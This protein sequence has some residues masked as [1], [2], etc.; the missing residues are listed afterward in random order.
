MGPIS[1]LDETTLGVWE[2]STDI[3]F[4]WQVSPGSTAQEDGLVFVREASSNSSDAACIDVKKIF[5]SSASRLSKPTHTQCVS[6]AFN[7]ALVWQSSIYL[8]F[9]GAVRTGVALT[10][11]VNTLAISAISLNSYS[12]Q[13]QPKA[14]RSALQP[15]S[16]GSVQPH[17]AIIVLVRRPS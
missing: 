8:C 10:I 16:T 14:N 5:G 9:H 4:V 7:A 2:Q 12:V 1:I 15:R 13:T 3:R 11:E 6:D 17:A